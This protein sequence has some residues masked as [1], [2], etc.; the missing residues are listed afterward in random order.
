VD[1]AV[2]TT[3]RSSVQIALNSYFGR[4]TSTEAMIMSTNSTPTSFGMVYKDCLMDGMILDMIKIVSV[5]KAT[6][7]AEILPPDNKDVLNNILKACKI[8]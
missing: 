8:K 2:D 1:K 7:K 3:V 5:S 4:M 6:A